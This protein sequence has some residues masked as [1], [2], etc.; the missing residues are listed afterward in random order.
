MPID[1]NKFY[2]NAREIKVCYNYDVLFF[3]F[4]YKDNEKLREN[5][6]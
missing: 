5:L 6:I 4:S 3:L 2:V 1:E